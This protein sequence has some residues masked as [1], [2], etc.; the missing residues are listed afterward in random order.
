VITALE[1]AGVITV[2]Q[3]LQLSNEEVLRIRGIGRAT[4][5]T[6]VRSLRDAGFAAVD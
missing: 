2:G 1:R 5:A 3:L 4:L 6:L